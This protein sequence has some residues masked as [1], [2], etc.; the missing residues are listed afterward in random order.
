MTY[1]NASDDEVSDLFI[2]VGRIQLYVIALICSGFIVLGRDF[3]NLWAGPDYSMAYYII[4]VLMVP[5]LINRS[6]SLGTQI[7]LARNK[8]KFRAILFLFITLLDIAISIPLAMKWEGLGAAIGTFLATL[9]GPIIIMNIYYSKK[10]HLDMKRYW[11]RTIPILL[12]VA[13][14]VAAGL[15]MNY[16]WKA[17]KWTVLIAQGLIYVA[18]YALVMYLIAF[19]DYE[20]DLVKGFIN[21]FKRKK[22]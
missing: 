9:I 12:L 22:A 6:Q 8:H 20:K 2:K 17:D 13:V 10:M 7:L 1:K 14:L 3:I 5:T 4:V 19:N 21:R 18:V 15:L 16:F 11:K